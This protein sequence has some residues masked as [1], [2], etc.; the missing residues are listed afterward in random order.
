MNRYFTLLILLS[1]CPHGYASKKARPIDPAKRYEAIQQQQAMLTKSRQNALQNEISKLSKELMDPKKPE[2]REWSNLSKIETQLEE[3]ATFKDPSNPPTIENIEKKLKQY[4]GDSKAKT[5]NKVEALKS[6]LKNMKELEQA[7]QYTQAKARNEVGISLLQENLKNMGDLDAI[8]GAL[9]VIEITTTAY[10]ARS[11]IKDLATIKDLYP[12]RKDLAKAINEKTR[13]IFKSVENDVKQRFDQTI[14]KLNDKNTSTKDSIDLINAIAKDVAD[15]MSN[16][17]E[18]PYEI[19]TEVIDALWKEA[20]QK[21]TSNGQAHKALLITIF[22]ELVKNDLKNRPNNIDVA[23]IKPTNNSDNNKLQR[24]LLEKKSAEQNAYATS[25]A[26][27]DAKKVILD[28]AINQTEFHPQTKKVSDFIDK[29]SPARTLFEPAS[30]EKELVDVLNTLKPETPK[31]VKKQLDDLYYLQAVLLD[32]L[33]M[34]Y[35][36]DT[37]LPLQRPAVMRKL[38]QELTKKIIELELQALKQ[39]QGNPKKLYNLLLEI[40]KKTSQQKIGSSAEI[41]SDAAGDLILEIA[42]EAKKAE[43]AQD[44]KE[45]KGLIDFVSKNYAPKTTTDKLN[46]LLITLNDRLISVEN[47]AYKKSWLGISQLFDSLKNSLST[48]VFGVPKPR[49]SNL[50]A[51]YEDLQK[52]MATIPGKEDLALI[53]YRLAANEKTINALLN[54]RGEHE[55][56]LAKN[57]AQLEAINTSIAG[58]EKQQKTGM[59]SSH[60]ETLL[61]P[62]TLKTTLQQRKLEKENIQQAIEDLTKVINESKISEQELSTAIKIDL[63]QQAEASKKNALEI[64]KAADDIAQKM[65]ELLASIDRM[66]NIREENSN[67]SENASTKVK[68]SITAQNKA[69][70]RF[71]ENRAQE[72]DQL[73]QEVDRLGKLLL[74]SGSD[75]PASKSLQK[76]LEMLEKVEDQVGGYKKSQ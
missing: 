36:Q 8:K 48:L 74:V 18:I 16:T 17:P 44:I 22:Q 39:A 4:E 6:L 11:L 58:L 76:L 47:G 19:K 2:N 67:A 15:L 57:Q 56:M 23:L 37:N 34:G 65:N 1:L 32:P 63:A 49:E 7:D 13:E 20:D 59:P 45:Q 66:A 53:K 55:T 3:L 73:K 43:R 26:T 21:I 25:E 52:R 33:T 10:E 42:S 12:N 24:K 51:A 27:L 68:D 35:P 70:V 75:N 64:K 29:M 5:Q 9:K 54:K 41:M 69:I 61:Q 60:G 30:V 62:E 38:T 72:I 14:Q 31:D 28:R 46:Q 40:D 50:V 71:F